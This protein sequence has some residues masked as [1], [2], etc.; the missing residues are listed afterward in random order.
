M[1]LLLILTLSLMS[2]SSF[3]QYPNEAELQ[4]IL[5]EIAAPLAAE[6]MD[7]L[8]E[9]ITFPF[10]V[11]KTYTSKSQLASSFKKVFI[12]GYTDCLNDSG[13]YQMAMPDDHSWY[14]AVCFSAPEGYE[15]SVF[16]F[17]KKDGV[18]MLE[19]IGLQGE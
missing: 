9:H 16:T 4:V 19:E 5:T 18:W 11:D 12:E 13:S 8:F 6:D 10:V 14:M 2:F 1:K 3:A 15:A 7:L 17:R